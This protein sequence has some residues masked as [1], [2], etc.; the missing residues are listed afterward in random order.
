MSERAAAVVGMVVKIALGVPI[1]VAIFWG[2]FRLA[3]GLG[4]IEGWVY[5]GLV[6]LG[7][8][9]SGLYLWIRD[10]ELIRRRGEFGQGTKAWDK[11]CLSF[12]GLSYF[13]I[14]MVAALDNGRGWSAAPLWLVPVGAGLCVVDVVLVTW[15]MAVNRFFEK[16]VRIQTDRGHKVVDT[17]PY[18]FIRHPGYV[19]TILGFIFAPPLMLRSWWAFVPA[20]AAVLSIVVRTA[21]EDRTLRRE[22]DGYAEYAG[23][24]RYRLVPGIW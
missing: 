1:T 21:L 6:T 14:L 16:T 9:A 22:L 24:V 7:R 17:G 3:G 5:V 19:A 2:F 12:F 20:A 11:V 18:R 4:W 15:A 23:R 10:P 13:G 8:S